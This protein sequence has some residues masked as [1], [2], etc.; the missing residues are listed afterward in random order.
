MGEKRVEAEIDKGLKVLFIDTDSLLAA[1]LASGR[2]EHLA[3]AA[4]LRRV[5]RVITEPEDTSEATKTAKRKI[6]KP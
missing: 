4:A 6:P 3:D 1:K 5:A 2:P